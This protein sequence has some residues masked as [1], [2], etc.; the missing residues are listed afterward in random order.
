MTIQSNGKTLS[1]KILDY[2][3]PIHEVDG[4]GDVNWYMIEVTFDDGQK[5]HVYRDPCISADELLRLIKK[6]EHMLRGKVVFI[7]SASVFLEP[8]LEFAFTRI[9]DEIAIGMK[10]YYDV[11]HRPWRFHELTEMIQKDDLRVVIKNLK[12]MYKVYPVRE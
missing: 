11:N 8:Y 9:G 3:F 7:S 1:F 2:Q 5:E 12:K 4:G 10:F 6:L